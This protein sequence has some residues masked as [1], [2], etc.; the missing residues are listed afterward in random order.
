MTEEEIN[1]AQKELRVRRNTRLKELYFN[2]AQ[3]L[4][5]YYQ[6]GIDACRKR[7]CDC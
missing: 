5:Y 3:M 2:E 4:N 7:T 1:Y 6:M